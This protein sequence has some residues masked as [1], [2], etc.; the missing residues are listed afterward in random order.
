MIFQRESGPKVLGA[1][2]MFFY[3]VYE[4]G[5]CIKGLFWPPLEPKTENCFLPISFDCFIRRITEM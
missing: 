2:G 4:R 5:T 3:R 1:E